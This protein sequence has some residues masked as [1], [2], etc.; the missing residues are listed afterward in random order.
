MN[1]IFPNQR[2]LP[3]RLQDLVEMVS[4]LPQACAASWSSG[5][6]PPA[7]VQV[8]DITLHTIS[9]LTISTFSYHSASQSLLGEVTLIQCWVQVLKSTR[10][11][12]LQSRRDDHRFLISL[13]SLCLN[14]QPAKS[15]TG[16]KPAP[17]PLSKGQAKVVKNP[18]FESTPKNFGIGKCI[19]SC[20]IFACLIFE[21]F[22]SGRSAHHRPHQ[23]CEMA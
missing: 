15:K 12:E 19:P 14:D 18:L 16:K 11:L 23:I 22:R 9:P 13:D 8:R 2:S 10:T 1:F 6:V 21:F 4:P 5:T 20:E 7:L 17:A 3:S